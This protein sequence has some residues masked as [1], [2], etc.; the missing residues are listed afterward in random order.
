MSPHAF[1]PLARATLPLAQTWT[2]ATVGQSMDAI[3][4]AASGWT[5]PPLVTWSS[6]HMLLALL[7]CALLALASGGDG[8]DDYDGGAP[9]SGLASWA[10]RRLILGPLALLV[11]LL[12]GIVVIGQP[13]IR[14]SV[15]GLALAHR[16]WATPLKPQV[17]A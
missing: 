8:D 4:N 12:L 13:T 16:L 3:L 9:A 10:T 5:L 2:L 11:R 6:T 7:T 15:A 14:L 17:R 1:G